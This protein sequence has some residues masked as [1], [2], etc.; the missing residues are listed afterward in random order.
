MNL[1]RLEL[2]RIDALVDAD[3]LIDYQLKQVK[4]AEIFKVLALTVSQHKIQADLSP[5][6][7]ITMVQFNQ[8]LKK[9]K[10]QGVIAAI[11]R[12]YQIE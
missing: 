11:L 5:N 2:N 8:A 12:K 3:I 7:P 4:N 9:L 10:D 1:I 6:A